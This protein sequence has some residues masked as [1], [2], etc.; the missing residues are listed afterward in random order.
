MTTPDIEW[1]DAPRQRD[2]SGKLDLERCD[3]KSLGWLTILSERPVWN[4][5]H[6]FNG[7]STPHIRENCPACA[8]GRAGTEKGY[9]ATFN[10]KT[11]RIAMAEITSPCHDETA[12]WLAAHGTMRGASFKLSRPSGN[13]K[14]KL[15]LELVK[16]DQGVLELPPCPDIMKALH[17]MWGTALVSKQIHSEQQRTEDQRRAEIDAKIEAEYDADEQARLHPQPIELLPQRAKDAVK[18]NKAETKQKAAEHMEELKRQ[19]KANKDR[20][21]DQ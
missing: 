11:K 8:A 2:Q 1:N 21:G 17:F 13:I 20:H 7:R 3:A 10:P 19:A 15:K 12:K 16:G 9:F 6:W 14:G 5:I 4:T 18:R